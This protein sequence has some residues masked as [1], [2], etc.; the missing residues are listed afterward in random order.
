MSSNERMNS[1]FHTDPAAEYQ[2][3]PQPSGP[4][5]APC[6][7]PSALRFTAVESG[8][9]ACYPARVDDHHFL[10]RLE[11]LGWRE[12]ELA[13]RLYRQPELVRLLLDDALAPEA[14]RVAVELSDQPDPPHVVVARDG[15]FVT[16]LA[17]GMSADDTP[18]V[19]FSRIALAAERVAALRSLVAHLDRADAPPDSVRRLWHSVLHD[20]HRVIRETLAALS[21]VVSLFAGGLPDLWTRESALVVDLIAECG[22]RYTR[23]RPHYPPRDADQ[24]HALWQSHWAVGHL[25]GLF[26]LQDADSLARFDKQLATAPPTGV[27]SAAATHLGFWPVTLRGAWCAAR[28]GPNAMRQAIA[29]M[30]NA[31]IGESLRMSS[32]LSVAFFAAMRSGHRAEARRAL[33]PGDLLDP[34]PALPELFRRGL[35][36]ALAPDALTDLAG[37]EARL[38][39]LGREQADQHGVYAAD[40]VGFGLANVRSN[41]YTN[42]F[43]MGVAA[44]HLGWFAH[45][46]LAAFYPEAEV[47]PALP[48]WSPADTVELLAGSVGVGVAPTNTPVVVAPKV[49]RNAPCPCGS[50][51]KYKRCCGA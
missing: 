45:A 3:Y 18:V 14:P 46:E 42:A 29:A 47:L 13:L 39:E 41:V 36:Q 30:H 22:R 27:F 19:A 23:E 25:H 32:A 16:C 28:L 8:A 40:V 48:L 43:T 20:G 4:R 10:D 31:E 6:N 11:R 17:P 50:G 12:T 49:G 51:K 1:A 21:P 15:A 24:L 33:D 5:R 2:A 34:A 7:P 26:A 9:R 38:A 35:A 44:T 37:G